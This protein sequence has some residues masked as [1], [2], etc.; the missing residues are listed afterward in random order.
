MDRRFHV[1]FI[2]SG[3]ICR[4]PIAEKVFAHEVERAGLADRVQVTSAGTGS[5]HVGDPADSRA[6]A[7]LAEH[8]YL[9]AHVARQVDDELLDADLLVALDA[10]HLRALRRIAPDPERV[11][12]LRSFDPD[13]PAGSRRPRSVLRRPGGLHRG[14]HDG[15]GGDAGAAGVREG[16]AVIPGSPILGCA[17]RRSA[18]LGG[19]AARVELTDGRTVVVK[20]GAGVAAEAAGLRWL[21]VP[22]GPP[23]PAVLA[24]DGARL[25][26]EHVPPGRPSAAAAA[27]FGRR[28]AAL[29]A[30]GA[31]AFGAGPP[32]TSA[33]AWI[34][35]APMRN[36]AERP[37]MGALV[38]RAPGGALPADGP[39][40]RG[41]D[42][43]RGR[44]DRARL[45]RGCRSWPGRPS[46]RPGCTATCGRATCCGRPTARG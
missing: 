18:P 41:P 10:G 38:R 32:G 12:L 13:A 43:R 37:G 45:R 4:S 35:R 26:T 30:E 42:R 44:R 15:P 19:G 39:R 16:A 28:L 21:A 9:D 22:N 36:V 3:N 5:W 1:S 7:L 27:E 6:A 29:H 34:G 11:R 46:R 20:E 24:L 40:R 17:V 23:V 14:P 2:C 31:P 33:D 8:G 25:V